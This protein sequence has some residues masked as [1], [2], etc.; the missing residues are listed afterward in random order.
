MNKSF[1]LALIALSYTGISL[2]QLLLISF[3]DRAY[4]I[5]NKDACLVAKSTKNINTSSLIYIGTIG[6][7][8]IYREVGSGL[9]VLFIG[10]LTLVYNTITE[11]ISYIAKTIQ[12]SSSKRCEYVGEFFGNPNSPDKNCSYK[13]KGYGAL[14]NFTWPKDKPCPPSFNGNFPGP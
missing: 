13:C 9:I 1:K 14:A 8:D 10:G 2:S 12:H 6:G 4:A 5:T 3:S 7:V 11:A